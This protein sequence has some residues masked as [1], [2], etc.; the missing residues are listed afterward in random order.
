[1]ARPRGTIRGAATPHAALRGSFT[2]T[3]IA[4]QVGGA[5]LEVQGA[6]AAAGLDK[7][8]SPQGS[9]MPA[10]RAAGA[11]TAGVHDRSARASAPHLPDHLHHRLVHQ[12]E[13]AQIRLPRA[14]ASAAVCR[15]PP[16][17]FTSI[18][19]TCQPMPRLRPRSRTWR[20]RTEERRG[21]PC[22][23]RRGFTAARSSAAE[24]VGLRSCWDSAL[25][26]PGTSRIARPCR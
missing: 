11:R 22:R 10:R 21:A 13:V 8:S 12:V 20:P 26:P 1:M 23:T 25:A 5:H 19:L 4:L 6:P 3:R 17:M 7:T 15:T 9:Q 16:H 24:G 18:I 14:A 2:W